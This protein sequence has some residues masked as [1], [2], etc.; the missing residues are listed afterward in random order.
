MKKWAMSTPNESRATPIHFIKMAPRGQTL[1]IAL[2][3]EKWWYRWKYDNERASSISFVTAT[4]ARKHRLWRSVSLSTEVTRLGSSGIKYLCENDAVIEA[5]N[6]PSIMTWR[7][8]AY[9]I[10]RLD[11]NNSEV[12]IPKIWYLDV[13]LSSYNNWAAI[14]FTF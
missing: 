3:K 6:H 9:E 12:K 7:L 13:F 2:M 10:S 4:S 1:D 8:M 14:I 5:W 11:F